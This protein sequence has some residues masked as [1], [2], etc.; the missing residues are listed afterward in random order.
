LLEARTDNAR[1]LSDGVSSKIPASSHRLL[2]ATDQLRRQL[3]Q[4]GLITMREAG[5]D[6]SPER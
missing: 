1:H 6:A 2:E 3:E 4:R 5:D